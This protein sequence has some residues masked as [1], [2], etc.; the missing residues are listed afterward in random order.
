MSWT[1][2]TGLCDLYLKLL[3]C[4]QQWMTWTLSVTNRQS[5]KSLGARSGCFGYHFTECL[6]WPM[7][8]SS[9]GYSFCTYIHTHIHSFICSLHTYHFIGPQILSNKSQRWNLSGKKHITDKQNKRTQCN[10]YNNIPYFPAHKTHSPP[11]K[12]WPKFDLRLMRRGQVLFP[13]L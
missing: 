1:S 10:T 13:T 2:L 7:V 12:T 4:H 11:R 9:I 6:Y 8:G 5:I 3:S